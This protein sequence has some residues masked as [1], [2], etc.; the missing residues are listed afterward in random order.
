[1]SVSQSPVL[2]IITCAIRFLPIVTQL[3]KIDIV[4]FLSIYL[5]YCSAIQSVIDVISTFCSAVVSLSVRT[6]RPK[7]PIVNSFGL[8]KYRERVVLAIP[9]FSDK[10]DIV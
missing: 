3:N 10:L 4:E 9:N 1:M 2:L 8:S 5:C 6:I 7:L